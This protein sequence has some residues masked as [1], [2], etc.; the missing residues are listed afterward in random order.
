[1]LDGKKKFNG[2]NVLFFKGVVGTF[3]NLKGF[4]FVYIPHKDGH[5]ISVK[6][7]WGVGGGGE[8]WLK[9]YTSVRTGDG[10]S[11]YLWL[12]TMYWHIFFFR[13]T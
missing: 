9:T 6:G 11:L 8:E 3:P 10:M 12:V 1:M 4:M 13:L 5:E 7:T 2:T